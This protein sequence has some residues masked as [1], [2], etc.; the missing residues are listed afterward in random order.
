MLKW[1]VGLCSICETLKNGYKKIALKF[2]IFTKN[3]SGK[4]NLNSFSALSFV[5]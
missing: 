3:G 4:Q 1:G 5:F 2:Q